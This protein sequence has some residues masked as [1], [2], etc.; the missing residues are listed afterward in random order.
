MCT[1]Y[2]TLIV[3]L[4]TCQHSSATTIRS[5]ASSSAT[6]AYYYQEVNMSPLSCP[7]GTYYYA[8]VTT[9]TTMTTA[10]VETAAT[11]TTAFE[12]VLLTGSIRTNQTL[13]PTAT[14]S[15]YNI[16]SNYIKNC[17]PCQGV[18]NNIV[19]I[20][21]NYPIANYI[22][23]NNDT[24]S[25]A[26]KNIHNTTTTT[27]AN[28]ITT[29]ATTTTTN[30]INSNVMATIP[31]CAECS[32]DYTSQKLICTTC[33]SGYEL[34]AGGI[35]EKIKIPVWG[36][37]LIA[38]AGVL[39]IFIPLVIFLICFKRKNFFRKPGPKPKNLPSLDDDSISSSKEEILTS[40]NKNSY[41]LPPVVSP[42]NEEIY[43][44]R[45]GRLDEPAYDVDV[46]NKDDPVYQNTL[47]S[48]K[49]G[50][51][52]REEKARR[53]GKKKWKDGSAGMEESQNDEIVRCKVDSIMINNET[54][55][56]TALYPRQQ[57]QQQQPS[58]QQQQ[59]IEN[60][61][62]SEAVDNDV[63]VNYDECIEYD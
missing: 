48:H 33:E 18:N 54:G 24:T 28:S 35:C 50:D 39:V 45:V 23:L 7:L 42:I 55:S 57:Q 4:L 63:Y 36:I 61:A 22:G 37:V 11:T 6:A 53:K 16:H 44:N 43:E 32:Y 15:P 46:E 52:S 20:I 1:R 31:R 34:T 56:S 30:N 17:Y 38:L 27:T 47:V 19:N 21:N 14:T 2:C 29:I 40:K 51:A 10:A 25:N 62:Y 5:S 9:A 60:K 49:E 41:P 8:A 26:T 58:Q 3:L 59:R 13:Y 12:G